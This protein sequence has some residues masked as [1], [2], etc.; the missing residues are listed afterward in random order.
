M[1]APDPT[2]PSSHNDGAEPSAPITRRGVLT[3]LK[4]GK[5]MSIPDSDVVRT[6]ISLRKKIAC[7]SMFYHFSW[8]VVD[9]YPN[10]KN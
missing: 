9:L 3:S 2:V 6:K 7:N 5:Q 1:L 4:T 10:S 8:V